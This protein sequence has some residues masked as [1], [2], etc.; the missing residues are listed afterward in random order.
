MQK[1][2]TITAALAALAALVWGAQALATPSSSTSLGARV[3]ALELKVTTLKQ[4][5]S[6]VEANQKC[7]HSYVS[8]YS[9]F[10]YDFE[11]PVLGHKI[12]SALAL[13]PSYS[14]GKYRAALV[15]PSCSWPRK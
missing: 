13:S 6:R 10:G 2:V 4:R 14:D 11:D 9:R 3:R 5:G 1:L 8:V 12:D 15:E 7:V